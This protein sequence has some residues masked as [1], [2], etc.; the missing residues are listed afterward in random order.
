VVKWFAIIFVFTSLQVIAVT[1]PN[2]G[3]IGWQGGWIGNLPIGWN[4]SF[5]T[6]YYETHIKIVQPKIDFIDIKDYGM[7]EYALGQEGTTTQFAILLEDYVFYDYE[8]NRYVIP[9]GFI[10]DGA[11]IPSWVTELGFPYSPFHEKVLPAGL[12][13]DYMYRNPDMFSRE[14]ADKMF[15]SNLIA[16]GVGKLAAEAMYDA[17][18]MGGW[19][20]HNGH[21]WRKWWEQ[22]YGIFTLNEYYENNLR[23]YWST[24]GNG[25]DPNYGSVGSGGGNGGAGSGSGGGGGGGDGSGS[26]DGTGSGSGS[27]DGL[28]TGGGEPPMTTIDPGY[29]L[30]EVTVPL[31]DVVLPNGDGTMPWDKIVG[32]EVRYDRM[33]FLLSGDLPSG[34]DF[35][36]AFNAL[37]NIKGQ[38]KD[39]AERI[40]G[41]LSSDS[42][43]IG[44]R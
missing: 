20:A 27:G 21:V 34:S 35:K 36:N 39:Q 28:G 32:F 15:R 12:I 3:F 10:F 24:H 4:E 26:G 14:Y 1:D 33:L 25:T 31:P 42:Q 38:I 41:E 19:W 8:G 23:I 37:L 17:L 40:S 22:K 2:E 30:P 29:G 18:R 7:T 11:S 5:K 43:K 6:D 13:H 9:A 44:Q 16:T